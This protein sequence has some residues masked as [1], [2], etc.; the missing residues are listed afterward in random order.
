[1]GQLE[2]LTGGDTMS[3]MKTVV[4]S[5]HAVF[6][7]VTG[8]DVV[9]WLHAFHGH[10][11]VMEPRIE[12]AGLAVAPAAQCHGVGTALLE[13]AEQWAHQRGVDVI[14]LRS[15]SERTAAHHFYRKRGYRELKT[16]HAFAKTLA[17]G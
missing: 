5:A 12:I 4:R 17:Y 8:D 15:G 13:Q 6:A 16:Q 2:E 3:A 11:L 14:F 9:G 1:V 10:S 7:A